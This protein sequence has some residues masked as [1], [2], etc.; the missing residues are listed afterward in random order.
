[1]LYEQMWV[2]YNLFQPVMHLIG[3]TVVADKVQRKWD[4]AQTPFERLKA[5]GKLSAE[6]QQRLQALYEQT[7][8][9]HLRE[10]IYRGLA[11]LW[12]QSTASATEVA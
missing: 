8:P 4:Q 5:T 12:E 1:V 9:R 7:N 2:Y 10:M 6:Q 11:Q 3:K